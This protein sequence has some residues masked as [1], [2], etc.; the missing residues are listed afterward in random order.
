MSSNN[1]VT[2]NRLIHTGKE[3]VRTD[4]AR[5]SVRPAIQTIDAAA[6]QIDKVNYVDCDPYNSTGQFVTDAIIEKFRH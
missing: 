6:L 4:S 1:S 3:V 5:K 2:E